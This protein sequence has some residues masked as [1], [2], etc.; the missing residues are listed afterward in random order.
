MSRAM[1]LFRME[2]SFWR[3][4]SKTP[5]KSQLYCRI[6]MESGRAEIGSTGLTIYDHHWDGQRISDQD[7]EAFFKNEQLDILR[8][9]LR[10][11]FNDLFR[12]REKI[13]PEKIKRAFLGQ[14]VNVSLLSAFSMYLTDSQ[15]DP[16]RKLTASSLEVYDNVRKKLVDFLISEKAQDLL[17][18]DFDLNWVKK[19]RRWMK[20]VPLE[21]G[22]VGHAD[23]YIVKHTQ[24]IK[25]VLVWAK[26][27]KLADS[28]P[29]E[30]LRI[31]NA[32]Y[33]DPVFLSEDEFDRLRDHHFT[34]PHMQ[35]VADV[36]VLLCRTGFH[37]GDLLD[38]IRK[39]QT[40]VRK[41]IDGEIWIIKERIKTE[42]SAKVPQFEEVK[43][44]VAKYGG[45][46]KLPVISL[47]KFNYWLKLIA[48]ELKLHPDLSS[49]AGRKT[50]T[51]WCFNTLHLTTDSVKVLLGRKSDKGLEVYGRPDERRVSAELKQSKVMQ[52]RGSA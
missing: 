32:E 46:E 33:G 34:N 20:Q 38:L 26:L 14:S 18:E 40:A 16:E 15:A 51:D 7:P 19:Y 29:L 5:G 44:I 3:H 21:G 25:N 12:K 11:I 30:G 39:H 50:F 27:H 4:K 52:K 6:T 9:Q 10:A 35:H 42:V 37:Y 41:G 24:T 2:I 28:N 1:N 22:K 47:P 13:T 45:W 36:F 17:V 31:K 8:N 43:Q 48:G 49:K 23:S